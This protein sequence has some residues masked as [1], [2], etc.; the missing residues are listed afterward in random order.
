MIVVDTTVLTE[1]FV[2]QRAS[3]SMEQLRN[4]DREWA[5]PDLWRHE[6]LSVV[7][8]YVRADMGT[9]AGSEAA[10]R[11]AERIMAPHTFRMRPVTVLSTALEFGISAYDAHFVALAREMS[12]TLYTHD[13][14][15]IARCPGIARHPETVA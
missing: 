2:H 9:V 14:R 7:W 15:L 1:V 5:A 6:L 4:V 3:T 11:N 13:R 10:M 12:T 8:K